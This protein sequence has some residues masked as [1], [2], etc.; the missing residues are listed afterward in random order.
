MIKRIKNQS[1]RK[2]MVLVLVVIGLIILA[3]LG[4]GILNV[5]FGVRRQAIVLKNETSAMLTAEAGYERALVW[6]EQQPDVISSLA[7]AGG[8]ATG[9]KTFTSNNSSYNYSI[10]INPISTGSRIVYRI[11]SNGHCGTSNR[12]VRVLVMQAVSGWD[13]GMCQIPI[14]TFS[15]SPVYFKTSETLDIPIHINK[16][17]DDPDVRDIW[18]DGKPKFLREVEMGES[19]G[20]K[21]PDNIM[22]L[23]STGGIS[24]DQP[25]SKITD[26]DTITAKVNRFASTVGPYTYTPAYPSNWSSWS[27]QVTNPAP[28]VQLEFF[29]DNA[30]VGKVRITNNC[31]VRGYTSNTYDYRIK[32]NTDG[33]QYEKYKIYGCHYIPTGQ[34]RTFVNLGDTYVTPSYG[35]PSFGLIYVNGNVVIGSAE[36]NAAAIGVPASQLNTVQGNISIVATGNIWIANS[37]KVADDHDSNGM[38]A[39]DNPN[40]VSMLSGTQGVIKVIDPKIQQTVAAADIKVG[41]ITYAKYEPTGLKNGSAYT[42]N[43]KVLNPM[44]VEAGIIVG[45]GG[46]GAENVAVNLGGRQESLTPLTVRGTITERVRGVVGQRY[47]FL[48]DYH[49]D[50]RLLQGFIPEDMRLKGKYVPVPAGWSDYRIPNTVTLF[51]TCLYPASDNFLKIFFCFR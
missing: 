47:G 17:N 12:T 5:A 41:A 38:P 22:E 44:V 6:M 48:K 18:I 24:F 35:G 28:A 45:G 1:S 36:E 19:K 26:E 8:T 7:A 49:F 50:E 27:S 42:N 13:M 2:G 29:V 37:I 51:L 11:V 23:F 32:A 16:A 31:V 39:D 15:T 40:I 14:G 25:D 21:Y 46:W 10:C 4:L 34:E 3:G 20:S 43:R 30:G 9:S 33:T